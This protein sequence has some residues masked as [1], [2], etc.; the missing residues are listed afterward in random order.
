MTPIVPKAARML[1]KL[2]LLAKGVDVIE[3]IV[4]KPVAQD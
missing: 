1:E 2:G 3:D 4:G